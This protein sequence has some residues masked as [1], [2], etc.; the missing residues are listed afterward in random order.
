[1]KKL[2]IAIVIIFLIIIVVSSGFAYAYFNKVYAVNQTKS[3]LESM[4]YQ[5]TDNVGN[6]VFLTMNT[7][8]ASNLTTFISDI[9]LYGASP[10]YQQGDSFYILLPF[11]QIIMFI[12]YTPNNS[13]WWIW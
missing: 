7:Q 4:G 5:V 13:V 8:S 11:Y 9:N 1:M 12:E 10:I 2:K 6:L 3:E